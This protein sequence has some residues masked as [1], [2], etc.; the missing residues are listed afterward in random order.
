ML[1]AAGPAE[2]TDG[3]PAEKKARD[4]VAA[5]PKGDKPELPLLLVPFVGEWPNS[6]KTALHE[7]TATA[8]ASLRKPDKLL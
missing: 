7:A 3:S 1:P 8:R 2:G 4:E 5:V 6:E